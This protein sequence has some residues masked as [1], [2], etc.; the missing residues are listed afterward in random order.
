MNKSI[1]NII[2]LLTLMVVSILFSCTH[3]K[4]K[5]DSVSVPTESVSTPSPVPTGSPQDIDP[6][7][8]NV[9]FV[10]DS[11]ATAA[12]KVLVAKAERKVFDVINSYCGQDFLKA[13]D[14]VQTNGRSSEEVAA[15][16]KSIK[17]TIPVHFYYKRFTSEVAVRY[18]PSTTINMNRNYYYGDIDLCEFA[19]T[20]AHEGIGH[21]L[22]DYDHDYERTDRRNYSVPYSLNFMFQKCCKN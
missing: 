22:G 18:P 9:K 10:T 2:P 1:K 15:H 17:G 21:V 4:V 5:K 8:V 7:A 12:E 20:L 14:M 16:L 13:R 6:G 3:K 11:T 19:G